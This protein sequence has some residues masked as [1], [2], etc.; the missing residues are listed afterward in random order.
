[1]PTWFNNLGTG[2]KIALG[3]A[4][5]IVAVLIFDFFTGG[6]SKLKSWNYHRNEQATIEQVQELQKDIDILTKERNDLQTKAIE[7]EA[8]VSILEG[9]GQQ[10]TAKQ[11]VEDQKLEGVL[12]EFNR[13]TIITNTDTDAYVR[14]NRVK[15]KLTAQNIASAVN[16]NCEQFAR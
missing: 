13:E 2:L 12:E 11:K 1:M 8:Q 9:R 6:L 14:C 16:I 7:Q 3:I 10:I 4:I 15:S 5:L